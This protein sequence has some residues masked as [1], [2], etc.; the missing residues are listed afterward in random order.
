MSPRASFWLAWSSLAV[1]VALVAGGLILGVTGRPEAPFYGYWVEDTLIA[2]TFATLGALI[3]SRR[4]GNV[5]GWIFLVSGV[6]A[7]LQ[8]LSGQYA[9]VVLRSQTSPGGAIAAWLSTLAQ[10][11]IVMSIL[12]LI[13]LFPTGRLPS[14]RWRPVAWISGAVVVV[15]MVSTAIRPG[16]IED[17]PSVRNPFGVRA[18]EALGVLDAVGVSMGLTCFAAA[19][20]SLIVRFYRSRGEERQQLKWFAYASTLGFLAIVLGGGGQISGTIVW[21]VAPLSLPVCAGIAILRYRLYEIDFIVNRTIVY[22]SLT[23]MLAGLYFGGVTVLQYALRA[24]TGQESGLAVVASTLAIAALFNPL[25]LRVQALVDR[26]F[27]RK[28]YDAGRVMAGF[29][30]RLRDETDLDRLSGD[31]VSVVHETV[32]PEHVSLWLR[33]EP[34]GYGSEEGR[35]P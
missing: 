31:L 8:L 2:P 13:L 10:F 23:A 17:F 35:T 21:T 27:Y 30:A 9:T 34:R 11:S 7:G 18:A 15:S 4:P 16:P 5:I 32:R 29:S 1:T 28:K 3:V 24:T 22:G 25:R 33:R 6:G 26:R 20:L 19:I 14:P 12:F